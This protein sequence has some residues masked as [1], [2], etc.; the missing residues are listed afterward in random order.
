MQ[1]LRRSLRCIRSCNNARLISRLCSAVLKV[2][3]QV[4]YLVR[5]D[6]AS[7]LL[8]T[9]RYLRGVRTVSRAACIQARVCFSFFFSIFVFLFPSV[10]TRPAPLSRARATEDLAG[11]AWPLTPSCQRPWPRLRLTRTLLPSPFHYSRTSR[12]IRRVRRVCEFA[13]SS[14]SRAGKKSKPCSICSV[15]AVDSKL[16]LKKTT[17][18]YRRKEIAVYFLHLVIPWRRDIL[19]Y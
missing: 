10:Q 4:V 19:S 9:S 2:Y 8:E 1:M 18:R 5:K 13:W 12:P 16:S 3:L 14:P 11:A 7:G 6:F 17:S 15:I